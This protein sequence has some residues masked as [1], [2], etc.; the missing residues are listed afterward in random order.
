MVTYRNTKTGR[1]LELPT[2]DEWLEAA[3]AEGK[4]WE[5]VEPEAPAKTKEGSKD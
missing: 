3:A 2:E 4:G 5:R 1:E